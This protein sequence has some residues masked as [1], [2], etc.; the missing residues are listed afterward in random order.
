MRVLIAGVATLLS[1]TMGMAQYNWG[2]ALTSAET[3]QTAAWSRIHFDPT[4]SNVVWASTGDLP[5]PFASE[6][7]PP[8]SGIWRSTNGGHSWSQMASGALSPDY[9]ILDFTICKANPNVIYVGTNVEGVFR[10]TDG[11][12]SWTAVNNGL[13]HK[14]VSMPNPA[15]GVGAIV[16]DPTNPNNVYCSLGQLSG[17]DIFNLSP[18]HPGFYYSHDGG[19]NWTA[20][21]DGLPPREDSI[22]D[23]VSNTSAPLSLVIPE[24]SPNTI[25]AG[26]L[27]AEAN[28][29][30]LFGTK[31]SAQVQVY[32]NTNAG[33]GT[34]D[35]LSAGLPTI[36][37]S[38]VLF[39]SLARIAA[40]GAVLTCAPAGPGAHVVYL[41]SI[42]FGIDVALTDDSTKSKSRGIYALAPGA[43]SWIAR[44]N[45]L[46]VVTND[47]NQ[48]AINA[49]PVGIHPADPYTALTGVVESDDALPNASKPWATVTA[50]DP[51]M[52]NWGDSGLNQ[53]PTLGQEYANALFIEFAP[54][55][56]KVAAAISWSDPDSALAE[57]NAD[58]GIYMI[59]AP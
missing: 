3:G 50:G 29:K 9:H 38:S 28:I 1:A 31:A 32:R 59:P 21:N 49:S 8:A 58:D 30:V 48:N 39:G 4:N 34:W 20:S 44:N 22:L 15:W 41:S 24:D 42:G 43:T 56:S 52:Q 33:M 13:T 11:G 23:F 26:L 16:V 51:W 40:G 2:P 10:S 45:G 36:D 46:P 14:G 19:A 6:P 5:D 12:A 27:T 55:A 25:Y 17:L 18:D 35:N 37:Q 57:L 53:S 47:D 7:A 54:N